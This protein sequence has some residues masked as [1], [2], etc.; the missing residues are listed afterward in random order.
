MIYDIL[1]L[2]TN[3]LSKTQIIFRANLSYDL[4]ER[5]VK[6]LV[7]K[8]H[9][10]RQI[11]HDGSA[12]YLLSTKGERL[13]QMLDQIQRDLAGLYPGTLLSAVGILGRDSRTLGSPNYEDLRNVDH[14]LNQ[15]VKD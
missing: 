11:S 3:S 9:L 4:S 8:G 6:F 14:E 10:M 1:L 13:L 2:C 7:E 12:K 5:Y 15:I